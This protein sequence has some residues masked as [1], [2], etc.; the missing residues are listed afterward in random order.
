MA[1]GMGMGMGMGYGNSH[2][3]YGMGYYEESVQA[4]SL[5]QKIKSFF[6]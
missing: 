6:S 2:T 4:P 5:S 3:G 1:T